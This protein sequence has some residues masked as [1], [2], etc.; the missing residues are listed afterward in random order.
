MRN[1]NNFLIYENEFI[2]YLHG[3]FVFT[4]QHKNNLIEQFK[5]LETDI[6]SPLIRDNHQLVYFGG[7]FL[8]NDVYY[9]DQRLL[10]MKDLSQD[11]CLF[12]SRQTQHHYQELFICRKRF[13]N[14]HFDNFQMDIKELNQFRIHT[15]PF[16]QVQTLNNHSQQTI[17]NPYTFENKYW[18]SSLQKHHQLLQ[19]YKIEDYKTINWN[20]LPNILLLID[21]EQLDLI[22]TK[23]S[24]FRSLKA[25]L[26]LFGNQP[27]HGPPKNPN[28]KL[29]DDFNDKQYLILNQ[30]IK[31]KPSPKKHY[32]RLGRIQQ[33]EYKL[34]DD[35]N[36]RRYLEINKDLRKIKK[37][38]Q[39]EKHYLK[40][41]NYDFRNYKKNITGR[42]LIKDMNVIDY[43]RYHGVHVN[44]HLINLEKMLKRNNN[45]FDHIF[46]IGKD[47]YKNHFKI[48]SKICSSSKISKLD[49]SYHLLDSYLKLSDFP[50]IPFPI[51]NSQLK[52]ICLIYQ[53]Y[54]QIKN[55][56][57]ILD[58]F[59]S[60][61]NNYSYHLIL[62]N[63][64][65]DLHLISSEQGSL[66]AIT[67]LESDNT[68]RE[69]SAYQ[70]AF[71]YL[72]DTKLLSKFKAYI[73]LNET[74]FTNFPLY[75]LD[76]IHYNH[77]N[78]A[79]VEPIILGKIDKHR[80]NDNSVFTCDGW[81]FGK[82]IRSNFFLINAEIFTKMVYFKLVHYTPENVFKDNK[83]NIPMSDELKQKISK[84]LSQER[85]QHYNPKEY[86]LKIS[87]ILN[88]Y[89][90]SQDLLSLCDLVP[91]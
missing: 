69:M 26:F 68:F 87:S 47:Y 24:H 80:R 15:T 81:V 5:S 58:Y 34:P 37:K 8:E 43:L 82:W 71:D 38:H 21:Q 29:P 46:I 42:L 17:I 59:R 1:F 57:K 83:I 79:V 62:V 13:Y 12:F 56:Q 7:Y 91:L 10:K 23:L 90:L 28:N 18:F 20:Q 32:L 85:Y 75:I 14:L 66:E 61:N 48:I 76:V 67:Y 27:Y 6:L 55:Y 4:N 33:R 54:Y 89:K 40:F 22:K 84:W 50:L 16:I 30:D 52:H 25:N 44:T 86:Q 45:L 51:R 77:I 63:N 60:L 78:R 2:I 39:A 72:K 53:C 36:W 35:F 64:N 49:D 88:E 31:L 73:L 65:S 11:S 3:M 70:T 9:L 41:G 74:L 19:S